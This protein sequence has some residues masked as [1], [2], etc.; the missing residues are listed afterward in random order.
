MA[1]GRSLS[2]P[3]FEIIAHPPERVVTPGA[4]VTYELRPLSSSSPRLSSVRILWQAVNDPKSVSWYRPSRFLG[5]IGL[6]KWEDARWDFEGHHTILCSVTN[7]GKTQNYT[8]EQHVVSLVNVIAT[9]PRLNSLKQDPD[10]VLD[11]VAR[12][13]GIIE[14]IAK[15]SPPTGD[16]AQK[17]KDDVAKLIDYRDRLTALLKETTKLRRFFVEAEHLDRETQRRTA[18]QVFAAKVGSEWVLVDWTNPTVR[19]MT[20]TY[21]G[22]GPTDREGLKAAFADWDSDNRYPDGGITFR[23]VDVPGGTLQSSFETDGSS[24]W[25][26]VSTFFTYVGLAAAVVAGV[27][28]ALAPVPGSQLV[29]AAIWTSIFSSTAAAT[30]NIGQRHQEG[31]SDW[32]SNAFDVL[33]IAGNLFGA[34]GMIWIRGAALSVNTSRGLIKMVLVGQIATDS[35]QGVMIGADT[36]DQIDSIR[37]DATLTPKQ[38][39]DR[40]LEALRSAAIAGTLLYINVKGTKTDLKNLSKVHPSVQTPQEKLATIKDPKASVDL[41]K[42]P[43]AGGHTDNGPHTTKVQTEQESATV[44][45]GGRPH[46]TD[47]RTPRQKLRDAIGNEHFDKHLAEVPTL[48]TQRPELASLTDDEIIAIRSYTGD[49]QKPEFN[50]LRDY[51]RVNQA[52]RNGDK[53][54]IAALRPLIDTLK[55]GLAKLPKF[56]G[57]VYRIMNGVDPAVI[58]S[59]FRKGE[60]WV[61]DAFMSTSTGKPLD[62]AQVTMVFS[63]TNKGA[64]VD[65]VSPFPEREALFSPGATFKVTNVLPISE[66][67]FI[68]LLEE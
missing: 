11:G 3:E 52:L 19:A 49:E 2:D 66:S 21:R 68:I 23:L 13:V 27:A 15:E 30:I 14:Q 26:S 16:L 53:G 36:A 18:L 17:H 32:R 43:T 60:S 37:K 44:H 57:T 34:A 20:G 29:S 59:Q 10:M 25:D 5:P 40:I 65:G 51:Q 48:R 61:S 38:K 67:R 39:L 54:D 22:S 46:P 56:N 42:S 58:K 47:T 8:Y 28:T 55:A 50:G 6:P 4:K 35:V 7:N 64:M 41:T 24:F 1:E 12:T 45:A 33:S 9:G 62:Q 31:F 63:K